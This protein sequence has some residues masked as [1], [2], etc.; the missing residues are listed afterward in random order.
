METGRLGSVKIAGSGT[1]G[2][3]VYED[4]AISGSGKI[5]GD[6]EAQGIAISGSG[7]VQGNAKARV[8][9]CSG[10][11]KVAGNVEAE[12][13]RC[14]GAGK[15]A[16]HVTAGV[17]KVSGAM[18]IGGPVKAT[19]ISAAGA[20]NF[21]DAV[22]CEH[23][24]ASGKFEIAGLLNADRVEIS[25][26]HDSH[27]REIGG[28]QIEIVGAPGSCNLFGLH[29]GAAQGVL[30]VET[31]EGDD[32]YLEDTH[33]ETVRGRR[34]VIGPGCRVQN[35]EYSESLHIAPG[36][37]VGRY[38]YTGGAPTPPP[39]D[40]S[41]MTRRSGAG[42]RPTAVMLGKHE[43]RNPV[44]RAVL[45]LVGVIIAVVVV[46]LVLTT[47]LP[48]VGLIVGVVLAGVAVLLVALAVGLPVVVIG[49]ALVQVFRLPWEAVRRHLGR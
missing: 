38:H 12:E 19:E 47:V 22:A 18:H 41:A 10:T 23:F 48:A 32:I 9:R 3:G 37:E 31:I 1:A 49:A 28:E 34:V 43:I 25:L 15:I 26:R 33:A 13:L 45:G 5:T 36:A 2:G 27:V 7:K 24:R 6:I 17:L 40:T 16:G 11:F 42:S 14:S 20:V 46:G 29:W 21:G 44:L 30:R 39:V 35:V 8:F 4:V